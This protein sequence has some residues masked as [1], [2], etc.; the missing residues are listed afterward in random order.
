LKRDFAADFV[1][2][3]H[4]INMADKIKSV[5]LKA[6]VCVDDVRKLICQ[7]I[8]CVMVFHYKGIPGN[9]VESYTLP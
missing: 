6:G 8:K 4:A 3:K 1:A 5:S 7:V 9:I 2:V